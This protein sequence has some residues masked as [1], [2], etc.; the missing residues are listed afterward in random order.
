MASFYPSYPQR[1][2][3]YRAQYRRQKQHKVMIRASRTWTPSQSSDNDEWR[4]T[5]TKQGHDR[6]IP[7]SKIANTLQGTIYTAND[8]MTGDTVVV[9]CA[10]KR[11]VHKGMTK[12]G[13]SVRENFIAERDLLME[14]KQHIPDGIISIPSIA[15]C[16][17]SHILLGFCF[18]YLL[19]GGSIIIAFVW[20]S[21][22]GLLL[23]LRSI[24]YGIESWEDRGHYY[25]ATP[26][27]PSPLFD[28]VYDHHTGH[29][30]GSQGARIDGAGSNTD[31]MT[32]VKHIFKGLCETVKWCHSHGYCHQDLS[33]ENV[34]LDDGGDAVII[35]LGLMKHYRDG[36]FIQTLS[37]PVGKVKYMSPEMYG[38]LIHDARM[39]DVWCL[40]VCLFMMICGSHPYEK[41]SFGDAAFVQM[42]GAKAPQFD[43]ERDDLGLGLDLLSKIFKVE[44]MRMRLDDVLKH[45]FLN[46]ETCDE[47]ESEDSYDHEDTFIDCVIDDM[48]ATELDAMQSV[49]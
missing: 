42:I 44:M 16:W 7:V 21:L 29:S 17:F 28:L 33:L 39:N 35:D 37:E 12:E 4:D 9:K 3:S 6:F 26:Y 43:F 5:I 18:T 30:Y 11:L 38:A 34:M 23:C 32:R 20:A 45:P 10:K 25:V 48:D 22:L 14:L 19:G 2:T 13:Y 27:Y 15:C 46:D 47:T 31:W 24:T 8:E 40:G 49:L 41:P 1:N 36:N